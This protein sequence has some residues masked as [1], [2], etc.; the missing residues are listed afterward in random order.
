MNGMR[1]FNIRKFIALLSV[2]AVLFAT[3]TACGSGDGSKNTGDPAARDQSG[4]ARNEA[5][6]AAAENA[7]EERELY[8]E[9]FANGKGAAVQAGGASLTPVT[10]KV[11]DGNEDGAALYISNRVNNWDAAD[12]K[13]SDI[14]LENGMVCNITVKGYVDADAEIPAGGQAWLQT[15]DSYAWL[16]GV[17]FVAGKPF[18]LTGKYTVDTGKDVAIRVQ[19]SE[20]GKTVPFYIGEITITGK[21]GEVKTPAAS[22]PRTPAEKFTTVTFEDGTEQGFKGRAG[23]EKLTVT[24]EANHTDG[25]KYA[26]KVEGRSDTWHGP[27]LNVEK[28]VDEGMEY[29]ISVWVKLIEPAITQIQLS[30]QIGNGDGANYVNLAPKTISKSDG[31]VLFEGQYRYNNA[32]SGYLTIY[33]ESANNA[34][35]SFYIDDIS[36]ESTGAGA[37]AIQKDLT[38]IKDVYKDD[39]LFGNAISIEDMDGIRLELLKMHHNVVTAGNAMKPLYLQSTKGNFNF[40][41][42][43]QL[44]DKALAEG[45]KVH[46]H[47]LVWHQQ[48]P[49]WMNQN[50]DGTYL[51]REEALENL[52]T[53]IRTVMEHFG[54]K[55]I[56]WDVVNEGMNDNP[57]KPSDWR[58][59]LRQSP[60]YH[61]IGD[62]YVEQAFLAA[63][64][65]L[66]EHPDWDIK[67]YYNDYNDDNQNKATAIYNM[68][69]ELNEKYAKKHPGKLLIDGVGMQGHYSI[70][71][72][73]AN[74]E[75][76]LER[77]I[78]LGVEVSISE[79]DMMTGNNFELSEKQAAA[80]GLLYAQLFRIF[81]EHSDNIARV[82]VWGMDDGTSWRAA[83]NPTLFDKNLQAKP[84]YYGVINPDKFVSENAADKADAN[85]ST[86]KYGTP[87]IDGKMDAAW[88]K[89][90]ELP[91]SRYQMAW[92]GA[93]GT[94][95]V[96]WDDKNLYVLFQVSDSQLDKASANVWEQDSVE[97][98][99]DENNAKTTFYQEDDGQFRVNY[100]NMATFNPEG[101]ETGFK[102]AVS[103]SGT[104][105]TVEM[106]IP[107]RTITPKAGMQIGF[108]AQINDGKDGARQSVAT[109]DDLTGNGYQDPSVF[110]VITL[111]K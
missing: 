8:R 40:A 25:G 7:D 16:G 45:F 86:A 80:Q 76:S 10:D 63:R 99:V 57:P 47:T 77:F 24:D 109:W 53:H 13:F 31:W 95:R 42:A 108:D 34:T 2:I 50:A 102:S 46:G 67:L 111:E 65:V 37:I 35:A 104:N 43:D 62:D 32:S 36:F 88:K 96:L 44:V 79:L 66:D 1:R 48:S 55:V 107:F 52:R 70:N 106:Q 68:V 51:G 33:V 103:V 81:R 19:S 5:G 61:A 22:G 89:A 92:Q 97:A 28:Y 85:K 59:S 38:P 54:N 83:Q 14:G 41:A 110:G 69:K 91:I 20:E 17:D 39:F 27:S 71:T 21:M 58:A 84:A 30:T 29:K 78:S 101:I 3:M 98:F 73:P 105:Y 56:S 4:P 93:D 87:K 11:F 49:E 23:T 72:N 82:T 15:V 64:E 6:D 75:L 94:A 26:L 74:V 18:T 100:E 9:T 12:F 60:W 90:P